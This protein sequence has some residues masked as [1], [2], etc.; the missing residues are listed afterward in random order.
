MRRW[1]V[2]FLL[3]MLSYPLHVNA[4]GIKETES[5]EEP[6]ASDLPENES[7]EPTNH[8]ASATNA[9]IRKVDKDHPPE[10]TGGETGFAS[11][12]LRVLNKV[13]ARSETFNALIGSV[14]RFGTIEIT[15]HSCW[16]SAPENPPENAALL[17]VSEVKKGESPTLFFLGWMFSSS[18][19]LSSLEH[20]FY[21]ITVVRCGHK[22]Q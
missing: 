6:E 11:V 7:P 9:S 13:T 10:K 20:P 17:E 1:W 12:E 4:A 16:K 3:C 8:S 2:V 22:I 19:G 15:A 18:P 14:A 5:I 21:D